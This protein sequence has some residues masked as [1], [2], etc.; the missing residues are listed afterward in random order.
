[1]KFYLTQLNS[2]EI[3]LLILNESFLKTFEFL[4]V[5]TP[6]VPLHWSAKLPF[7]S[8]SRMF[9][10]DLSRCFLTSQQDWSK[11][12]S[13]ATDPT[14]ICGSQGKAPLL[15]WGVSNC[16]G[17]ERLLSEGSALLYLG[18]V[19]C[20]CPYGQQKGHLSLGLLFSFWETTQ[21]ALEQPQSSS[22]CATHSCLHTKG[23]QFSSSQ[24]HTWNS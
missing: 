14:R 4:S 23:L 15:E 11:L 17:P 18:S 1:M 3:A 7:P 19:C 13:P 10:D 8:Y 6:G 9:E 2:L 22:D 21:S 5:S 20:T 12:W 24:I 16:G